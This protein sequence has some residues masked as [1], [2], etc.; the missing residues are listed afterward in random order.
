MQQKL[1]QPC[2]STIFHKKLILKK[3]CMDAIALYQE[4]VNASLSPWSWTPWEQELK[5]FASGC[6]CGWLNGWTHKQPRECSSVLS[7]GW[8]EYLPA[9]PQWAVL[10]IR[11][12]GI[13]RNGHIP[14]TKH[15]LCQ[16]WHA[17]LLMSN[18]NAFVRKSSFALDGIPIGKYFEILAVWLLPM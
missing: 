5:P 1:T 16:A 14:F 7:S 17:W 6:L 8:K 4:Y 18:Q 10:R 2:Q 9:K 11:V 15:S 3:N 12:E 13:H